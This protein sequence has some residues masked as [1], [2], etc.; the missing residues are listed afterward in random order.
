MPVDRRQFLFGTAVVATAGGWTTAAALQPAAPT[1]PG[2]SLRANFPRT[3][4]QTYLN[5]ASQHPLGRHALGAME[6]HLHY[7]VFGSGDGRAFFGR[8]DQEEL[9]TRYGV[10]INADPEEIAFVQNTSDGEN[11]VVA[12]MDLPRR[13]GNVV[14]DDLHFITSLYLY[15]TLEAKGLELR[16]VEHRDGAMRLEDLAAAIDDDTRLVSLALVSNINGYLEEMRAIS[17]LAHRRGAY[18]YSDLVQ[19]VGAV[20][21]DVRALGI[22]FGAAS[23][24]KWLMA[25]RGFGL[26][27]VRRDLQ[28]TVVPT[29]R[30]GHRQV[31]GFDRETWTW[32]SVPGAARYETGSISEV[33]AAAALAG[34]RYLDDLKVERIAAHARRL[35]GRLQT[36]LPALG[37]PSLTPTGNRSPIVAFRL[38]DPVDTARRMRDANIAVTIAPQDQRMRVSVSVFN[39]DD[40]ID[41]LV[42]ALT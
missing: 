17:D 18:V 32:E 2:A 19:A 35:I 13:G 40:D 33:L 6:R 38:S 21:V 27:Y 30:W 25:E 7:E 15:K 10:L 1:S 39:D 29:T 24:Y 31:R 16:V 23:T 42:E 11:I 34:V 22:D 3:A 8:A 37:Y 28:D 4:T 36:E 9:K 5:S 26:L 41:R 12:G 20:P 14:V